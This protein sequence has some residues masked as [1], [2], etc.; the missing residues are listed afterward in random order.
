MPTFT[1]CVAEVSVDKAT[2]KF[3]VKKLTV[4]SDV[5]TPVNPDGVRSQMESATLWGL[6]LA[7][8]ESGTIKDGAI[9]AGNYDAYTPLRMS[10][11]PNLDISFIGE[12]HYPVGIG[13]PPTTV[14]APAIANAIAAATGAR[15]RSLPI[16]PKKVKAAL[17]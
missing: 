7:I 5:G 17:I 15:V 6:S 11:V 3:S 4:V 13:E 1:A 9:T 2:G 14:V 8:H 12:G 10:Q 16:T